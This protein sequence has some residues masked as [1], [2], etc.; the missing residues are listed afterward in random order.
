MIELL[1]IGLA[2]RDGRWLLRRVCARLEVGDL[3]AIVSGRAVERDALIDVIAGRRIPVE[4][5]AWINRLPL[6]R[7]TAG[8]V[9]SLVA[10]AGPG[11]ALAER[12]SVLWNALVGPG[13]SIADFLRLPRRSERAAALIA[14]DAV[15][16]RSRVRDSVPALTPSE[17]ARLTLAR[18]LV[19][20]ARCVVLRDVDVVLPPAD[21]HD[22][23]RLVARIAASR[24]MVAVASLASVSLARRHADRV[25]ELTD[26][27]PAPDRA[28]PRLELEEA[29]GRPGGRAG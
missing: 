26:P 19:R 29:H 22:V 1:G 12:R 5:R 16:L 18:A 24:R 8:R 21:A 17:C 27:L 20:G 11:V 13:P 7:E 4:G 25:V 14:L 2:D 15:G 3:T 10:E 28:A 23:L 6:M 9:R